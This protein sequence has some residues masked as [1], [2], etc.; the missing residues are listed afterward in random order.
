MYS[1]VT[2][3]SVTIATVDEVVGAILILLASHFGMGRVQWFPRLLDGAFLLASKCSLELLSLRLVG[4]VTTVRER[5]IDLWGEEQYASTLWGQGSGEQG[6]VADHT[7]YI[8]Q[9]TTFFFVIDKN[10][11]HTNE[12]LIKYMRIC[13]MIIVLLAITV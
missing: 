8:N 13:C 9:V 11:F 5:A 7:H 6:G 1:D 12:I 3:N 4:I 2:G 10:V